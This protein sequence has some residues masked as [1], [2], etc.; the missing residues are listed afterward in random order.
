MD[1][2]HRYEALRYV[3]LNPVRRRLTV[4]FEAWRWSMCPGQKCGN[5]GRGTMVARLSPTV[6]MECNECTVT[7]SY[8]SLP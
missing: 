1:E 5:L 4:T 7:D 6:S 3:R 8:V 2:L